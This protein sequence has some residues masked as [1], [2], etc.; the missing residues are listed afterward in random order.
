[1]IPC[2]GVTSL[3]GP[4]TP[5][6]PFASFLS[7]NFTVT[8][9]MRAADTFAGSAGIGAVLG[10]LWHDFPLLGEQVNG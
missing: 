6:Y 5:V 4:G 1:M 8:A 7:T 2:C 10:I 9:P 3:P